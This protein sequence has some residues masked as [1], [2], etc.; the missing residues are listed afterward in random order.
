MHKDK[1]WITVKSKKMQS[2]KDNEKIFNQNK[3]KGSISGIIKNINKS[4]K[5]QISFPSN[6]Y[7]DKIDNNERANKFYNCDM[8]DGVMNKY[9][10]GV[11]KNS[12]LNETID[13]NEKDNYKKILCH[14]MIYNGECKY[15]SKCAYAH[16]IE[17]QNV[18]DM[19]KRAYDLLKSEEDLSGISLKD[20]KELYKTLVELTR[21]CKNC[22]KNLCIGGYNCK[23]GSCGVKFCIC[24]N[25]LNYGNC[26]NSTCPFIHLTKRG[27]KPYYN[28][29]LKRILCD[30][31]NIFPKFVE[32][33]QNFNDNILFGIPFDSISNSS[34]SEISISR[35]IDKDSDED[36]DLSYKIHLVELCKKSIFE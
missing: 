17:E 8:N 28:K 12:F 24:V 10:Y 21:F 19:R 6:N 32:N 11:D 13:E 29:N 36:V 18:N 7:Y 25:D 4:T 22:N 26:Q 30:K 5:D 16:D 34:G 20:D 35:D 14:N 15:G 23:S 3:Q 9:F 1:K 2:L 27:L 33:D 31:E